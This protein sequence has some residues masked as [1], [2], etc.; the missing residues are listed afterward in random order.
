M[1]NKSIL[2]EA[3]QAAVA[4]APAAKPIELVASDECASYEWMGEWRGDEERWRE[5]IYNIQMDTEKVCCEILL[6]KD[7]NV[8]RKKGYRDDDNNI[9]TK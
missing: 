4:P 8:V 2:Y 9:N 6:G 3:S 7:M 5:R 1:H